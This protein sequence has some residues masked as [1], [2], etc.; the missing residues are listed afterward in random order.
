MRRNQVELYY[1]MA[2]GKASE[3]DHY[4]KMDLFDFHRLHQSFVKKKKKEKENGRGTNKVQS[5][6]R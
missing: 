3:F 5:R 2:D 6:Q 1:L 4:D